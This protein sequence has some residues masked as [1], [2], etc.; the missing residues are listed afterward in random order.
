[1]PSN[2]TSWFGD[3][4][5]N[6]TGV[7]AP[8]DLTLLNLIQCAR[9]GNATYQ[10]TLKTLINKHH[11][12]AKLIHRKVVFSCTWFLI[13]LIVSILYSNF[14]LL[15]TAPILPRTMVKAVGC[16]MLL[17]SKEKATFRWCSRPD[18]R[19]WRPCNLTPKHSKP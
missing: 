11:A 17:Q 16:L 4:R 3:S 19:P 6:G 10:K 1:M 9:G 14:H 8:E 2:D 15:Y 12:S 7:L 13:I 5:V 18:S